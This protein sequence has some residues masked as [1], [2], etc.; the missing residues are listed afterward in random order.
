MIFAAGEG[1]LIDPLAGARKLTAR[2]LTLRHLRAR[3][4][5]DGASLVVTVPR[6][7]G[8]RVGNRT[9]VG[10]GNGPTVGMTTTKPTV[11]VQT[12]ATVRVAA[13]MGGAGVG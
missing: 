4:Y 2:I 12:T 10:D 7:G 5:G 6:A 3:R 1:F 8:T 11:G 13:G 9:M